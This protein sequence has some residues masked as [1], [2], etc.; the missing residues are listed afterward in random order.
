MLK[1]NGY[2]YLFFLVHLFAIMRYSVIAY[3]FCFVW[4]FYHKRQGCGEESEY[5]AQGDI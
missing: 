1:T 5:D 2:Q 3:Y 4:S